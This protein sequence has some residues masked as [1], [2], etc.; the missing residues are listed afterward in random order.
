M[1]TPGK[2]RDFSKNLVEVS[3]LFFLDGD[4]EQSDQRREGYN[5]EK[6]ETTVVQYVVLGPD[7]KEVNEY[8]LSKK[9]SSGLKFVL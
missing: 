7:E 4:T 2:E 6:R 8:Y 1:G 9:K 5:T 3:N